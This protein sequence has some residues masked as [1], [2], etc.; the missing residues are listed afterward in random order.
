[1]L[2]IKTFLVILNT[3]L[4]IGALATLIRYVRKTA[5]IAS[6]SDESA[7]DLEKTTSV[8]RKAVE[9]SR[10]VLLEMRETR[11]MLTTPIVIVYFERGED[12]HIS[13]LFFIIENVGGGVARNIQYHFTPE[14][15]G[16]DV[17]SVER[18]LKLGENIDSLPVGYRM[19]NLF[20]RVGHYIDLESEDFY[21][22]D[23]D[24]PRRFEV[25][26]TF[27]DAVTG[28]SYSENYSLDLGIPLGT[29][30]Q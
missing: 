14:L 4:L 19:V 15:R 7:K 8:S 1:M 3:L 23:T 16:E 9:L 27:E 30:T 21:E 10:N 6:L 12:K 2:G 5:E 28:N 25:A 13:H 18:I 29:C 22:F 17:E 20:G 24:L 26:I 11:Q